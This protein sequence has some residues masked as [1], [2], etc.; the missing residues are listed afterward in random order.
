MEKKTIL[1]IF[2]HSNKKKMHLKDLGIGNRL[3]VKLE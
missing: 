1:F 2:L 3:A